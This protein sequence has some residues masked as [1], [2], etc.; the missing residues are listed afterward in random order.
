M[1]VS[2]CPVSEAKETGAEIMGAII[3]EIIARE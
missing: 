3:T 2:T 1:S